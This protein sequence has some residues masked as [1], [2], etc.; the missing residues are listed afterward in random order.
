MKQ[1]I[2][3]R[4]KAIDKKQMKTTA[5]ELGILAAVISVVTLL[6]YAANGI[7]PFGENSGKIGPQ[8]DAEGIC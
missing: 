8:S 2:R 3:N 4:I 7:Y 1:K 5:K 6:A